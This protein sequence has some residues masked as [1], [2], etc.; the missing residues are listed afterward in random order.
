MFVRSTQQ[1]HRLVVIVFFSFLNQVEHF[2]KQTK[3]IIL[4]QL[5]ENDLKD[6]IYYL[7]ILLDQMSEV[8]GP[9]MAPD[10]QV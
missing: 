3:K 10:P 6:K 5:T 4:S 9:E 8:Y 7:H 1:Q 2:N